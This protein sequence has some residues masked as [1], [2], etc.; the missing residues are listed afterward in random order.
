MYGLPN[1][2]NY[3]LG[4][5][6]GSECDTLSI[7]DTTDVVEVMGEEN[8]IYLYPNPASDKIF[9]SGNYDKTLPFE[10][11]IYNSAGLIQA[12][13]RENNINYIDASALSAGIYLFKILQQNI[14][15][16]KDK[17]LILK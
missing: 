7:N 15:L 14:E 17:I 10:V 4:A 9:I 13:Y 1:M 3:N 2:P 12:V 8:P 11:I 16:H 6:V 5:L